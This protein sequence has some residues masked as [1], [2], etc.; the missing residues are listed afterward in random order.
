MA[1]EFLRKGMRERGR[2]EGGNKGRKEKDERRENGR[3]NYTVC[4]MAQKLN[5]LR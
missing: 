4:Y 1:G 3:M 2:K 5:V